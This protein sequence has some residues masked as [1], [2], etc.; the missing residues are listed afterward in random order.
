MTIDFTIKYKDGT[1]REFASD[2]TPLNIMPLV[3]TLPDDDKAIDAI[4]MGVRALINYTGTAYGYVYFTGTLEVSVG[5][6]IKDTV[7]LTDQQDPLASGGQYRV[8]G[9]PTVTYYFT[10]IESWLGEYGQYTIEADA[11]LNIRMGFADGHIEEKA[12][13]GFGSITLDYGADPSAI[14]A[15][16]VTVITAPVY[17]TDRPR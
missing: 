6:V 7:D 13:S 8:A 2:M 9:N 11:E 4:A 3:I 15:L 17:W 1:K 12:G 14:T 16:T 5:G 10:T